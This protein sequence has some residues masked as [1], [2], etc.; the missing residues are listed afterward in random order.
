VAFQADGLNATIT[1][2]PGTLWNENGDGTYLYNGPLNN[3]CSGAVKPIPG[4]SAVL[5]G[6]GHNCAGAATYTRNFLAITVNVSTTRVLGSPLPACTSATTLQ[7]NLAAVYLPAGQPYP[8]PLDQFFDPGDPFALCNS[9][10]APSACLI[11][12]STQL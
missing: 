11:G 2:N 10:I 4:F 5:V 9:I 7:Y 8:P 1:S 6:A 3:T 12:P